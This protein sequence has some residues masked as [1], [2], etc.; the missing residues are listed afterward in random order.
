MALPALNQLNGIM[1]N[2]TIVVTL[3]YLCNIYRSLEISLSNCKV[4]LT[5]RWTKHCVL[6]IVGAANASDDGAN[7]YN[8]NFAR[9]D[10][11]LCVPIFTLS[12][13]DNQKLSKLYTKGFEK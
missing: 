1:K 11:R 6:S 4:E 10:T 8:I 2:L 3:K 7:S 13:K 12:A 9:I 5:T